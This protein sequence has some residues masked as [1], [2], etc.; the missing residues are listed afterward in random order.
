MSIAGNRKYGLASLYLS[1]TVTRFCGYGGFL[2][3]SCALLGLI[4][5]VV[6]SSMLNT[7][8]EVKQEWGEL[9]AQFEYM[10]LGTI[11][12]ISV[13]IG[14]MIYI[15]E[16]Q[17]YSNAFEGTWWSLVIMSTVGYGDFVPQSGVG[18]LLATIL[19]MSG[20]CMFAMVTAVVSVKVGRMINSTV[21]CVSCKHG[22]SPDFLYCPH[23]ATPLNQDQPELLADDDA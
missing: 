7:V 21:R 3:I 16:P 20:I 9:I 14:N 2:A 22:I 8:A 13:L 5:L 1:I 6:F 18:K 4:L 19:I 12:L 11:G 15:L 23:C 10:V 17:T